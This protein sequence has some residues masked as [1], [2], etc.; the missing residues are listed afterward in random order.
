MK[1][2]SELGLRGSEKRSKNKEMVQREIM[3][4]LRKKIVKQREDG[5]NDMNVKEMTGAASIHFFTKEGRKFWVALHRH[6]SLSVI[7]PL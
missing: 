5:E 4:A 6:L 1:E 2:G 3:K 7:V